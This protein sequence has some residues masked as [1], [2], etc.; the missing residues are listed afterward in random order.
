MIAFNLFTC[1]Y[2]FFIIDICTVIICNFY[3]IFLFESFFTLLFTS[4]K[5]VP[6]SHTT[7]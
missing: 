4:V 3:N 7:I 5:Y 6:S 2:F 1:I